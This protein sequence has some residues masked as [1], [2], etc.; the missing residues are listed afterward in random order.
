MGALRDFR[1]GPSR[2]TRAAMHGALRSARLLV[3]AVAGG[4]QPAVIE[5]GSGRSGEVVIRAFSDADALRAAG[6]EEHGALEFPGVELVR[7]A[8]QSELATL[9]V[10]P[11]GPVATLIAPG[12]LVEIV[13]E[14]ADAGGATLA[15]GE[16]TA[17][18]KRLR[19]RVED[20]LDMVQRAESLERW[21]DVEKLAGD[22]LADCRELGDL[23]HVSAL[24]ATV[25][26]ARVQRDQP[27]DA[28]ALADESLELAS[29][30]G[31]RVQTEATRSACT[32]RP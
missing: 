16:P 22:V 5:A 12:A 21:A 10:N 18:R 9:V 20:G 4:S 2:E 1:D 7:L 24:L 14:A 29:S 32:P 26:N 13:V 23:V 8:C 15:G 30:L 17:A 6:N 27:G 11:A 31:G 3:P 25:A 28:V 19:R